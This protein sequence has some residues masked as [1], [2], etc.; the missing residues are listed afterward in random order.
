MNPQLNDKTKGLPFEFTIK[1]QFTNELLWHSDLSIFYVLYGH[2]NVNLGNRGHL[3]NQND[4]FIIEP[5]KV[6]SVIAFSEDIRILHLTISTDFLKRF[7]PDYE[8]I[9]YKVNY[10]R[11]NIN[12]EEHDAIS[13]CISQIVLHSLK[14]GS[15]ETIKCIRGITDLVTILI[16]SFGEKNLIQSNSDD[17]TKQR[18]RHIIEYINDHFEEKIMLTQIAEHLSLH[19]QYFSAFFKKHF[20]KSFIDFLTN[21]RIYRSISTLL[22]TEQSILDIAIAFGFSNHKTYSSAF[23]KTFG[24][25]PTAYRQE[26]K[27][28]LGHYSEETDLS[29]GVFQYF[30]QYWKEETKSSPTHHHFQ[31]HASV[32]IDFTKHTTDQFYNDYPLFLD[33][34]RASSC[35]RA[36]IQDH[37]RIAKNELNFQHLRLRDIFSDD[38]FV[39]HEEADRIPLFNW[40]YIDIIIDFLQ[41]ISVK[42][43]FELGF[44]PRHLASKKQYAGWNF[45]PNVS[46]PKSMDKWT[47][48]VS[49]FMRHCIERYGSIEVHSWNFDFW[50]CPDLQ[51]QDCY[52]NESMEKFFEF[53]HATYRAIKNVSPQLKVGV[54]TFSMPNGLPWYASF[55]NFCKAN[56]LEPSYISL[57]LYGSDIVNL[58]NEF[59]SYANATVG[60]QQLPDK[61]FLPKQI[62][63]MKQLQMVHHMDY[64][65]IIVS[66]WNI[67]YLP[68]DL[69]K[70]T[71]FMGPY[72]SYIY[73][74]TLRSVQ[75]LCFRS[76]SD[77]NEDFFPH[78]SLFHGGTGLMDFYGIKKSAY[79]AYQFITRLGKL[80]IDHSDYYLITKSDR[81]YQI[82]LFNLSFY[83]SLYRNSDQSALTYDSRY[84]IYEATEHLNVHMIL[85]LESGKYQIKKSTLNRNS[86]SAYDLWITMGAP[87]KLD[88]SVLDYIKN[89]SIPDI[90]NYTEVV[91]N[92]LILD[93]LIE[94][95]E[96]SLFEIEAYH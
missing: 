26:H 32:D 4:L 52:W 81:G 86:G 55:F 78:S 75:G 36:E 40:Q 49:N 47:L 7:I 63:L 85:T 14:E 53:Y 12:S 45:R 38:L 60:H 91:S 93:A 64:L 61:D 1:R 80:V 66:N 43:F 33:A 3:F 84:N 10:L 28:P 62:E 48:L 88:Q 79:Y 20:D 77:V 65:P 72:I 27:E 87:K 41:S 58:E 68:S 35:L 24:L 69:S 50:V 70:D 21:Y 25:S 22:N 56:H 18:I 37:I 74:K 39:Y 19:P 90:V 46:F 15:C 89:K 11:H 34:G 31:R 44:M 57:H 94:P 6:F 67:S 59:I 2:I 54:P 73:T 82:L 16:E 92:N 42:P 5:L 96:V 83:D 76:L 9:Q 71:S 8:L 13:R 95:H 29:S 30:Q 23:K 17:Y 51:F